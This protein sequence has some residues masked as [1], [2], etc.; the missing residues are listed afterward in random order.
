MFMQESIYWKNTPILPLGGEKS[1]SQCHL[2]GKKYETRNRKRGEIYEKKEERGKKKEE[3]G[4][5]K[6]RKWLVKEIRKCTPG[7]L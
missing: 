4:N 7:G 1:I 3:R 2:G 5:K 6:K